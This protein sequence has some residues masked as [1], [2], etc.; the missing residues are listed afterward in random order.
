MLQLAASLRQVQSRTTPQFLQCNLHTTPTQTSLPLAPCTL[1][2]IRAQYQGTQQRCCI[3]LAGQC[4]ELCA[5]EAALW[6]SVYI[7]HVMALQLPNSTSSF[8]CCD[9]SGRSFSK[10]DSTAGQAVVQKHDQ[11][12]KTRLKLLK[13]PNMTSNMTLKHDK[14]SS[15]STSSTRLHPSNQST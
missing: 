5:I 7:H 12:H 1:Q 14:Q 11:K 13:N 9:V 4:R 10:P 6:S 15:T 3:L 2:N 8:K